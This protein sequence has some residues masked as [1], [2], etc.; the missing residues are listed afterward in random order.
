MIEI[1]TGL[2]LVAFAAVLC[3]SVVQTAMGF[4]FALILAPVLMLINPALVPAPILIIAFAQAVASAWIHRADVQWK[5]IMM[6]IIGRLPGTLLAMALMVWLGPVALNYFVAA[7]VLFAVVMSIFHFSV[8]PTERNHFIAG[9]IS[10]VAGTSSGI[11][12][13]PMALLYQHQTGD[14]VRANLS[15][16]FALGSLISLAGMGS[17][18]Y[19]T[20]Q[21]WFYAALFIPAT[22]LGFWLGLKVKHLLKASFMRP[23]I[24]VLCSIS[25]LMVLLSAF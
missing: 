19:V 23:A 14:V 10:G 15:V 16:Y 20:V 3:A 11:A 8:E 4:G 25:A 6:A 22:G 17:I 2:M 12:G 24:L 5:R 21:S 1:S 18:G 7:G 13:P 9:F